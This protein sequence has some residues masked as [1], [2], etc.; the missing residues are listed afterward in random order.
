MI[1]SKQIITILEKYSDSFKMGS[2]LVKIFENPT[3]SD[4]KEIGAKE[5]RFI[6]DSNK[7]I[8]YAWDANLSIHYYVALRLK[9]HSEFEKGILC[10]SA[11]YFGSGLPRIECSTQIEVRLNSINRSGG[12]DKWMTI[13]N[14]ILHHNWGWV[15][16]Y[17]SGTSSY[18]EGHK[19]LFDKIM[20]V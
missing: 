17:I 10:C 11:S 16:K 4:F 3:V 15:D 19:I 9:Y 12:D 13:L 8:V 18:V 14:N 7:K 5:I 2:N 1:T 20:G 6:A